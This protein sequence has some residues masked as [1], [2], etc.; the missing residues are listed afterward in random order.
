MFLSKIM[1]QVTNLFSIINR[2]YFVTLF[3]IFFVFHEWNDFFSALLPS[4]V[5]IGLGILLIVAGLGFCCFLLIFRNSKDKAALATLGSLFVICFFKQERTIFISVYKVNFAIELL[6]CF[7]AILL[8]V[9]ILLRI[10]K[11]GERIKVFLNLVFLSL[12]CFEAANL[13]F[14]SVS[15]SPAMSFFTANDSCAAQLKNKKLPTVYLIVMDE[16][17][18]NESL[19]SVFG[20][21]NQPFTNGL[22][23]MGFTVLKN[24]H[25]NYSHTLLSIPSMFNGAYHINKKD[26]SV[27]SEVNSIRAFAQ[28]TQNRTIKTFSEIGYEFKNYS[29]FF[30]ANQPAYYESDFIPSGIMLLLHSTLLYELK[31][32][33]PVFFVKVLGK[34][35]IAQQYF[36]RQLEAKE[37][38]FR[39]VLNDTVSY[40][41]AF[42]YLHAEIPHAPY[43][44]DSRGE[45]NLEYLLHKKNTAKS[46][47][48]Y[49]EYVN[50]CNVLLLKFINSL[51]KSSKGNAVILL[52]S[53]HGS[54]SFM[55]TDQRLMSFNNL[56]AVYYPGGYTTG[57]YN[58]MTNVNQFRVLFAEITKQKIQVLPD[59]IVFR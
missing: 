59:S 48:A 5:L 20:V 53:D 55:R 10:K 18:G 13:F 42:F 31:R 51:K 7:I 11:T 21:N 27:Y 45:I 52:M 39:N 58:G 1:K 33:L 34:K 2:N 41:P 28:I 25:S 43:L 49:L 24:T 40:K 35:R 56:N 4:N 44:A 30:V 14:K 12:A 38:M 37:K 15:L 6:F 26:E 50:Y 9:I 36:S 8:L 19:Q 3:L 57:W 46:R 22:S 32:S 23:A 16:Y 17:P 47:N 29:P 54:K